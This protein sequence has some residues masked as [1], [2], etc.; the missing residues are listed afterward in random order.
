MKKI[1]IV[2]AL[3]VL[4]CS[5]FSQAQEINFGAKGGMNLAN[6]SGAR[7]SRGDMI[8]FHVGVIT[9]FVFR[10][11][12]F[13]LQPELLYSRQGATSGNFYKA[14]LDYLSVPVM[15][16]FFPI[17]NMSVDIGPQTSF[18]L[19]Y[20]EG[21]SEDPETIR[22]TGANNLDFGLNIGFGYN[23]DRHL[24]AHARYN[25]GISKVYGDF[26]NSVLQFSLGYKF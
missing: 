5:Q 26:N 4:S 9:E 10:R 11:G 17:R 2:A 12:L 7:T 14:N 1:M 8:N 6:L 21:S 23:L 22:T 3:V 18:L 20:K 16:K 15:F 13:G 25:L 19:N 24:F